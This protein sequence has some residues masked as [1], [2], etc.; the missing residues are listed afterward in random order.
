[1]PRRAAARPG[2]RAAP[3]DLPPRMSASGFRVGVI[4]VGRHA[5]GN[6]Y[7]NLPAAGLE[8]VATCARHQERAA[9]AAARWGAGH[10]FDDAEEMLASVDLDGVVICVHATDY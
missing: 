10:A 2:N 3:G 8:L 6:L 1:M 5:S 7:P 9:A 4:G